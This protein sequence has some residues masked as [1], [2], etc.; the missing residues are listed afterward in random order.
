MSKRIDAHHHLWRY[1]KE[2]YG[3]IGPGM[4]ALACDFVAE[5]AEREFEAA[6]ITGSVAVQ[7][8]QTLAETEW[9]LEVAEKSDVIRGVVGWAPIASREL[10]SVLEKWLR[11]R[12]LKGLRHAVQDERDDQ[13]I[14]REDFNRG[15]ASLAGTGLVYDI[16]IYARHLPAAISFVDRHPN[17]IFVLDHIAKP[18]IKDRIAE[19]WRAN[20]I[21]LGKRKNVYCK[22]SGMVTEAAWKSWTKADLQPYFDTAFE[23]FGP[24]R[25][26]FASDWPVCLLACSYER[27]AETVAEF[28]AGFSQTEKD[29]ILGEVAWRVYALNGVV[30]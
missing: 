23:A 14:L 6:G 30:P 25:L 24:A 29:L 8:Q 3:W 21:E 28:L 10:G 9:L 4:E 11:H 26:M 20:F 7:A 16:L 17:Q 2:E 12:K 15:I 27:W 13:F 19:P 22:L 18:A 5:D 1:R